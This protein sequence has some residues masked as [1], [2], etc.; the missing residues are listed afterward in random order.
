MEKNN[1]YTPLSL[2]IGLFNIPHH[3]V[4][5][6][7]KYFLLFMLVYSTLVGIL[8]KALDIVPDNTALGQFHLLFSF[9]L[10][11]IIAF[12]INVAHIRWWE[13]RG[14]WGS[15]VNNCRNLA[16]K[17]NSYIGLNHDHE[18]KEYVA[19]LPLLLK[20]HLRNEPEKC[21]KLIDE[22]GINRN[23]VHLP[24]LLVQTIIN[25]ISYYRATNKISFEQFLAMDAHVL[26]MTDIIGSCEK[27]LN[28]P[29]PKGFSIF[30]RFA[31]L[32]YMLIFPFGW[33]DSFGLLITPIIMVIIYVLLGLEVIAEE[34][35]EPFGVD[36][37]DLPLDAIAESI[38]IHVNQI[39]TMPRNN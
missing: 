14:Q 2:I 10:S 37:N 32:F 13:G 34:M 28:T 35:E 7:L 30:T 11:I 12:R 8:D 16:M 36:Y 19:K 31:L 3:S 33:V 1:G 15:L 6:K 38:N 18:F 23:E 4:F 9:C 29:L 20:Y 5:I 25:K 27:I 26:A 17:F 24:N 22:L 21:N 39:A